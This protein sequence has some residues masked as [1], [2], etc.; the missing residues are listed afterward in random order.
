MTDG[1]LNDNMGVSLLAFNGLF[2]CNFDTMR[3]LLQSLIDNGQPDG[4]THWKIG[5][6]IVFLITEVKRIAN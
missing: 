3:I 6:I 2:S 4:Q 1:Y 5:L